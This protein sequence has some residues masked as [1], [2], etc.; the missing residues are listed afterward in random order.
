MMLIHNWVIVDCEATG[1]C[2]SVGNLT[3]IG[4]VLCDQPPF[5]TAFH[6]RMRPFDPTIAAGDG[7]GTV[8]PYRWPETLTWPDPR[9]VFAE[10][11]DWLVTVIPD[12]KRPIFWSDNPAFDFQWINDGFH[13]TRGSNPFGWSGRRIG[14]LHAGLVRD[15][16]RPWKH[17]RDTKH[18]HHPV[19]DARGNAEALWKM[20]LV[21][22]GEAPLETL[23]KKGGT[24]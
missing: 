5:A 22:Q 8:L 7:S 17:L 15:P 2:P 24:R 4:A 21:L 23:N 13:R 14:D 12:G 11:A 18:T 1:Q 3:E 20:M 16:R 19:D 6:G 9:E 10:F